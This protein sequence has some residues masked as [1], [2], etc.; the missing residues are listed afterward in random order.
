M[1]TEERKTLVDWLVYFQ[2]VDGSHPDL[3]GYKE[4]EVLSGSSSFHGV[5]GGWVPFSIA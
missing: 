4:R 5:P 1:A 3:C 2:G